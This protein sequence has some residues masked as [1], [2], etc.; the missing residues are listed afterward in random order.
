M[1]KKEADRQI[2]QMIAFIRQE[3]KEKAEEIRQKTDEDKTIEKLSYKAKESKSIREEFDKLRKDKL[4]QKKIHRSTK[5]NEARFTVMRKRSDLLIGLKVDILEALCEVSKHEHYETFL[6]YCIVEGLTIIMEENV[7]VICRKEDVEIVGRVMESAK[8]DFIK[9]VKNEVF[10]NQNVPI[11]LNLTLSQKKFLPPHPSSESKGDCCRGGIELSARRGK[12]KMMN[13]VESRLDQAFND[14][15]PTMR[16]ML[17]G[18]RGP[19]ANAH[20]PVH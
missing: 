19:P 17:F 12:I 14:Q 15:K 13:T 3:A 1:D 5:I 2:K 7:E 8:E 20:P 18:I 11:V 4:T 10:P 16:A 9:K 6:R